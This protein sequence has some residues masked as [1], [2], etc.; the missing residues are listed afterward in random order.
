MKIKNYSLILIINLLFTSVALS[1]QIKDLETNRLYYSAFDMGRGDTGIGDTDNAEAIFYNPAALAGGKK[2][3]KQLMLASVTAQGSVGIQDFMTTLEGSDSTDPSSYADF[4]G[5]PVTAAASNLSALVFRR[6]AIGYLASLNVKALVYKDPDLGAS[7]VIRMQAIVNK[8]MTYSLAEQFF[9][10][11]LQLGT[12]FKVINQNYYLLDDLSI[13]DATDVRDKLED[14][15]GEYTGYGLDFGMMLV[16]KHKH[17]AKLGLT[18]KDIGNTTLKNKSGGSSRQFYQTLNMGFSIG[19]GTKFSEMRFLV[20]YY[21]ILSNVEVS[22]M[23]KL[24]IG[25]HLMYNN[26]FGLTA[27]LNQ[28]YPTGGFFADI[29]FLRADFVYYAAE[30]GSVSGERQDSRVVVRVEV[31]I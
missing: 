18:I 27:G 9:K 26:M 20:D 25:A 7:E 1:E 3:F 5:K 4:V 29:R 16:S 31:K 21:D 10:D 13:V 22:T 6:A 12:T 23:K 11:Y 17:P 30:E 14:T 24:H 15:M 8:V 2:F 28:G 19:T